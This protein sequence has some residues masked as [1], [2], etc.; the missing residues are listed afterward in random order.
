MIDLVILDMYGTIV[1][2][3]NNAT[4]RNGF[5][6][7]INRYG[8]RKI[9][10]ATD[11]DLKDI[12]NKNL[13]ALGIMDKLNGV[14]TQEDMLDIPGLGKRKNLT[15]ICRDFV[16]APARAVF[17]S[18]GDRDLQD[19]QRAEVKFVHVPY[20]EQKDEP[21][22]FA[23]IDLSNPLAYTDLRGINL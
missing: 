14:Y 4:P 5:T 17:I 13:T 16:V 2:R 23:I 11:D 10:L 19:A 9:V 6:E 21:F 15:R 3:G 22:S 1:G 18:D 20:Y 8:D 12:V 7:F